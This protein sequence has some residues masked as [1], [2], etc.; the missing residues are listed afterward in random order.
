MG[1]A[2]PPSMQSDNVQADADIP[3]NVAS[4]FTIWYSHVRRCVLDRC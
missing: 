4:R 2:V 3:A 1:I